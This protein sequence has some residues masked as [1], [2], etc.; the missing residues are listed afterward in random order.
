MQPILTEVTQNVMFCYGTRLE[1]L[2]LTSMILSEF[3]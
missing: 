3:S 2:S 1:L